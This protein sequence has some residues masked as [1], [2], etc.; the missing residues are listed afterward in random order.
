MH[1]GA[2][3]FF[4]PSGRQVEPAPRLPAGNTEALLRSNTALAIDVFAATCASKWDGTAADY[5]LILTAYFSGG[6]T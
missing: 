2:F 4:T 1:D 3:T 5:D 6:T